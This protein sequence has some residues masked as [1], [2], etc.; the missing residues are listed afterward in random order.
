MISCATEE[1]EREPEVMRGKK[2]KK[3]IACKKNLRILAEEKRLVI[4]EFLID[5]HCYK[6]KNREVLEIALKR[7][8]LS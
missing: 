3:S 1:K 2:K 6:M 8:I 7:N 4:F 5:K